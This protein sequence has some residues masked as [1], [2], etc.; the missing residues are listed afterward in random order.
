M[1]PKM[2]CRPVTAA[3]Y[4]FYKELDQY[5][6]QNESRFRIRIKVKSSIRIRIHVNVKLSRIRINVT[7][8]RNTGRQCRY[9]I[10]Q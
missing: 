6:H 4:L 3:L 5:P 8:L 1:E 9:P 7:R 10:L 2:V